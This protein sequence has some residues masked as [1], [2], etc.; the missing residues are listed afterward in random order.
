[1]EK[2]ELPSG[3]DQKDF[4]QKKVELAK[5]IYES[6]FKASVFSKTFLDEELFPYNIRYADCHDRFIVYR[7]GSKVGKTTS[8]AIKALHAA[9]FAWRVQP[10]SAKEHQC[11]II[12][13]APTQAQAQIMFETI[14]AFC[15]RNKI[16]E[17]LV[18]RETAS[19]I[20]LLWFN[21]QGK[22]RIFTR[23]SGERGD[24][25]RG[26]RP[27]ILI[28]DEAAFIRREVFRA[29][30]PRGLATKVHIWLISTPFGRQ[31]YF[32]EKCSMS[33]PEKPDG[34]W[35]QFRAKSTDN[36]LIKDDP[37]FVDEVRLMTADQAIQELDG[38]FVDYA[39]ALIP[40]MLI[41]ESLTDFILP[42]DVRYFVAV[43]V[44]RKGRDETVYTVGA[45]D[46]DDHL[47]VVEATSEAQSNLVDVAGKIGELV[48]K[49][50][51]ELVYVDETAVGAGVIDICARKDIPVRGIVFT[52]QS[53]GK[54]YH[55]LRL[56]FEEHKIHLNK[57]DKLTFQLG[58]LRRSFYDNSNM[59]KITSEMADDYCDSL[60]LLCNSVSNQ[61]QWMYMGD[62]KAIFG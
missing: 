6:Q 15:H 14:K 32:Y 3:G 38:E 61:E 47:Y 9:L 37:E 57:I 13:I 23:A 12:I 4:A 41:T 55:Q 42:P 7:A 44:A 25:L 11:D 8:T 30:V 10:I 36:P 51:A 60:A 52:A 18:Y 24:S 49:W 53:K 1:M 26:Y 21:G 39:D 31:G 16:I 20:E 43:D 22:S 45:V 40:Q 34:K 58:Y 2:Y 62:S 19:Q 50:K 59:V 35:I 5:L 56:L 27:H 33:K 28:A 29:I 46:K 48:F 54:M 17:K